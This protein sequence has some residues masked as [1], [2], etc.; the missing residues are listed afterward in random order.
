MMAAEWGSTSK[1]SI[2]IVIAGLIGVPGM[3][4]LADVA[5]VCEGWLCSFVTQVST[6]LPSTISGFRWCSPQEFGAH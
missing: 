1:M 3:S 4:R 2:S 5:S 6:D